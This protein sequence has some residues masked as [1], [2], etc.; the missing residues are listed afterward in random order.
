L[1]ALGC[2]T[3][4]VEAITLTHGNNSDMSIMARNAAYLFQL[5][6]KRGLIYAGCVEPLEAPVGDRDGPR[7]H[8]LNGLG[9]IEDPLVSDEFMN[10]IMND[11]HAV[12][13]LIDYC[14]SN[15]GEISII[16]LGP[17]SNIGAVLRRD[18]LFP[19]YVKRIVSMGACFN[20]RGNISPV[21]EANF[22]NDRHAAKLVANAPWIEYTIA[23][24]DVTEQ[25]KLDLPFREEIRDIGPVGEFIFN[26]TQHYFDFLTT[27][28][29]LDFLP[30]HDSSAV[31]YF[32]APEVFTKTVTGFVDVEINGDLTKGQTILDTKGYYK[33]D[34]NF[35]NK[36]RILVEANE[37]LFKQ[38]YISF[39][40][41][42]P[43]NQ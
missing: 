40:R 43:F 4:K 6:N 37:E 26:I 14:K 39:I 8:G 38:V 31:M 5:A 23:P 7:I 30:V 42:L 17:L 20:A 12:D 35:S 19:S 13:F 1:L 10:L 27:R 41:N 11:M 2:E 16:T 32:I 9:N 36:T 21:A 34:P 24:L 22:Y 28:F 15:I 3:L 33:N 25:V 29:K 18:P